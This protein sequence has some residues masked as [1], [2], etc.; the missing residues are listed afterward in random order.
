VDRENNRPS[1]F[2]Q[3]QADQWQVGAW[4]RH[5]EFGLGRILERSGSGDNTKI[6]VLFENGQWKKLLVKYAPIQRI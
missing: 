1:T 3:T 4:V 2:S 6:T 5:E